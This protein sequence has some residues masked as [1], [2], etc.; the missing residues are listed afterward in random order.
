MFRVKDIRESHSD[1]PTKGLHELVL[2][3]TK[4]EF[5]GGGV[6]NWSFSGG[7]YMVYG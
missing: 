1:H 7:M 5:S 6:H 3:F 4:H 2:E